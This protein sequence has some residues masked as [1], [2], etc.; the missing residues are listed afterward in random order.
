MFL[1]YK[2]IRWH[3]PGCAC[4]D[5][6]DGDYCELSKEDVILLERRRGRGP[7]TK[8][9]LGFIITLF[10][11]LVLYLGDKLM[12]RRRER[13]RLDHVHVP[14]EFPQKDVSNG[15]HEQINRRYADV[16]D[17]ISDDDSDDEVML[18]VQIV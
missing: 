17:D 11:I 14:M 9:F 3:H 10:V 5:G 1:K 15:T 4:I 18:N 12:R 8:A 7:A 6:F 2:K 13:S 16:E